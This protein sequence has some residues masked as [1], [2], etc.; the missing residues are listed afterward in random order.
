MSET[1]HTFLEQILADLNQVGG[2]LY[3]IN[4]SQ[5]DQIS[6]WQ[7]ISVINH[8]VRRLVNRLEEDTLIRLPAL[9]AFAFSDAQIFACWGSCADEIEVLL[10]PG[11][12]HP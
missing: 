11:D 12:F 5:G 10:S 1:T 7:E 4:R 8:R 9:A 3:A 6:H 2:L